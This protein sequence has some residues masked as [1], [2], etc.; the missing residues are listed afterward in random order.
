MGDKRNVSTRKRKRTTK[1]R[2]NYNNRKITI[3]FFTICSLG[4]KCLLFKT[5]QWMGMLVY[6]WMLSVSQNTNRQLQ[7]N[8][9]KCNKIKEE[10]NACYTV[11]LNYAQRYDKKY[12]KISSL[13]LF[14]D[15]RGVRYRLKSNQQ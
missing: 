4:A 11:N 15:L 9:Y 1:Q 8:K 3:F 5:N 6:A 10:R 7:T 14:Y 12:M 13:N 2:N